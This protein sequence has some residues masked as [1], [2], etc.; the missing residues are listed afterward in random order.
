MTDSEARGRIGT[1]LHEYGL[2]LRP[3]QLATA[4]SYIGLLTKWNDTVNLTSLPL[5]PPTDEAIDR[6][7]VE[8]FL[9]AQSI[10]PPRE[11]LLDVGSG[12]GSPAIPLK[13]A[14]PTLRLL[15]V[16]SKARKSAFLRE[17]IR[18]LDLGDAEVVTDRLEQLA[19]EPRFKKAASWISIR[20]V[21]ADLELWHSLSALLKPGG[22][23][24]WFRSAAAN[25]SGDQSFPAP[26][27]LQAIRPLIA[28]QRSELAI[29][30][31][32]ERE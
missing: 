29:L 2:T 31:L 6:L 22:Q 3:E 8:P 4:E 21:R 18:E 15:M 30:R 28:A 5:R 19:L 20:A 26:F 16:E 7:L 1:R 14:R 27:E 13:I 23:V 17:A 24:L 11:L 12:S 9:A 32:A 10:E 25:E